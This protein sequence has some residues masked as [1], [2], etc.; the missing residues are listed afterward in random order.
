MNEEKKN[1]IALFRYG[2]IAPFVQRQCEDTRPW[3]FFKNA[4]E[5]KYENP[6]G[7]MVTISTETI[8]RWYR[9][10]KEGGFDALKPKARVDL[11]KQRKLDD[12][13]KDIISHYIEEY[14]RL[15]AVQIYES[16]RRQAVLLTG[17]PLYPRSPVLSPAIRNQTGSIL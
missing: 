10:Y 15:P 11:G 14:P 3:T 9:W 7:E 5:R 1:Q 6:D 8:G 12:E 13:L 16:S 17:I 4:S 2:V